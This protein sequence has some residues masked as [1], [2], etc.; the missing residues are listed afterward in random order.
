MLPP[1]SV[2]DLVPLPKGSTSGQAIRN[3]VELA[4]HV[5]RL[6]Y[7][8]VWYAE[9]HNM[10]T[11]ASTTPEIMIALAAD[12]TE[13]IRV[14]SGG[15]MLPNHAPLKVAET[16]KMLESLHPG[17]IDLGIGRA[18]GTDPASAALLR[19][20]RQA[21]L[22][23]DD[24]P[25]RLQD[26]I[27]LGEGPVTTSLGGGTVSAYPL[28]V[29]LPPIVL[30][31]SSDYSAHL[32]ASMGLGFGFAAHFSDLDPQGP[33]L[34]YRREFQPGP[35]EKPHAILTLQV[36]CAD[37]EDEAHFLATSLLVSFARLRTGQKA[38]LLPPEEAADYPFNPHEAA[39]AQSIKGRIIAGNPEQVRTRIAELADRTQA[40]EVMVTTMIHGHQAR[41]RSYELLVS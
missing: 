5:D 17:R 19:G 3:S 29:G 25:D 34:A 33:M 18:P 4:K 13:N 22:A 30:L 16:F 6:G 21:A 27:A 15:V 2:L 10:P 11:I 1:L 12:A 24:F 14:G 32:S 8:R 7:R 41:L 37:T 28:D 20:S 36:V 35:L 26:L 9:H 40:D 39:V 23:A 38:L 31:G